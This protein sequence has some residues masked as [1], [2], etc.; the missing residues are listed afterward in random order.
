M[1]ARRPEISRLISSAGRDSPTLRSCIESDWYRKANPDIAAAPADLYQH[2]IAHGAD[3]GR[4]PCE[5]PLSLLE[6]LMQER[7]SR[8]APATTAS[9]PAATGAVRPPAA[10]AAAQT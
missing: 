1:T 3:E 8:P 4:L 9:A 6:K 5:D 10:T 2:W 7:M